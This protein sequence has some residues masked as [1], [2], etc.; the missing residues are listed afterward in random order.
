MGKKLD[1]A[2]EVVLAGVTDPKEVM[3]EAR[4]SVATAYAAIRE[5]ENKIEKARLSLKNLPTPKSN[6][7]VISDTHVPFEHPK[8]IEHCLRTQ[9]RFKCD[10]VVHIGDLVDNHAASRFDSEPTAMNVVDE[11]E[12]TQKEVQ[13]WVKAF[14][15]VKICLGN[16]DRIP[17]RQAKVLGI[18]PHF[19]KSFNELYCL[20]ETWEASMRHVIDD[21]IYE[22]GVG[23]GGMY[24]AK[25]TALQYGK[26]FVQGHTHRFGGSFYHYRDDGS[27]MFGLNVGCLASDDKY[28][29]NY[30]ENY[31][32]KTTL[33]C[34][35]VIE[36]R[37][38]HFIPLV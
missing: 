28:N 12:M 23:S 17:V 38:G 10:T 36:G 13:R 16:H 24:G 20:P 11:L 31:I 26:S 15:N 2:V 21:V 1:A 3:K 29:S 8:A 37:E 6:V 32:G 30:A 19:L 9:E 33:G 35:V 22:H 27:S 34:G 5:A 25:N 7:L 18:S 14:P 4:V